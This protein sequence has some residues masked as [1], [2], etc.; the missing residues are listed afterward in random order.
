MRL[1]SSHIQE[2]KSNFCLDKYLLKNK[3]INILNENND[4]VDSLKWGIAVYKNNLNI[5]NFINKKQDISNNLNSKN[6]T[7]STKEIISEKEEQKQS[8]YSDNSNKNISKNND[9]N[10]NYLK[11]RFNNFYRQY[12]QNSLVNGLNNPFS[13]QF[14][15]YKRNKYELDKNLSKFS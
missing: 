5:N 12:S 10:K 14:F 7:K 8:G 11:G 3:P 6:Y 2:Y 13:Y 15:S 9:N 4:E 1:I